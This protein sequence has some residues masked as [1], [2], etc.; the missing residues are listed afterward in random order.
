MET[1]HAPG[2]LYG[3]GVG[4]GD[5][6]LLTLRAA[7]LLRELPVIAAPVARPEGGSYA[8]EIAAPFLHS[9]QRVLKLHFPMGGS[10]LQRTAAYRSAASTLADVLRGGESAAFLTEGDPLLYST[11]GHLLQHLP[12][13]MPVRVVPGVSAVTAAAAHW[14]IPLVQGEQCLAILPATFAQPDELATVL[15]RFDT[16]VLLKVAPVLDRLLDL[17][18]QLDLA[19]AACLVERASHPEARVVRDVH[20][21]RGQAV[22]YLSLMIIRAGGSGHAG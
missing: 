4:P 11:F 20:S 18:D 1:V 8:L 3:I 13:E 22:H 6:E 2:T 16:V 19:A 7:R 17:L 14:P 5:P 21:L 10:L 12:P 9:A 15:T